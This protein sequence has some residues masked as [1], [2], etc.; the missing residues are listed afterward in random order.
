MKLRLVNS[1]KGFGDQ[2]G[3][4]RGSCCLKISGVGARVLRPGVSS[5]VL[6][7]ILTVFGLDVSSPTLQFDGSMIPG[8]I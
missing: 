8:E 5:D 6:A 4:M 3:T 7:G 2:G 1:V